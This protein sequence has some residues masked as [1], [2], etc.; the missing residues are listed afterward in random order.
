MASLDSLTDPQRAILQLLLKRGKS[1]EEIA[2]LLKSDATAVQGRAHDA[3][4]ALGPERPDIG[5]ERR[6]EIADYLLGQQT[7]SRRAATREY[8]QDSAQGRT[9]ARSVGGAL[10]PLG[11]DALPEIPS[12]P[13]E[14][15][16]AFEALD[17]RTER[18]Q[19][20]ARSSQLG[21]K[22]LFGAIGLAVAVGLILALGIFNGDDKPSTSTVTRTTPPSEEPTVIAAGNLRAANN[23]GASAQTAIVNYPKT[24]RYKLLV[25]IKKLAVPPDGS[26][27]GV[28]LYYAPDNALFVGFPKGTVTDQGNLDVVA[29]L[30]PQTP[31][32]KQVLVTREHVEKPTKPGTVVLRGSLIVATAKPDSTTT[33]TTPQTTT[34]P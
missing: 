26:A 33:S 24:N 17:R 21:T 25:A 18:Q 30:E 4:A 20:V 2:T 22:I 19:E 7:A 9:W 27:Y 32:P 8:L 34:T 5:D 29:D 23:S 16:M 28:W 1:Y 11:G 12:E 14:V 13:A 15:D 31:I 3:V 10:R 6:N